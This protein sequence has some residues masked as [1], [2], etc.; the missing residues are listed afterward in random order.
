MG[1]HGADTDCL[2][3]DDNHGPHEADSSEQLDNRCH[4]GFNGC[5][6]VDNATTVQAL[7]VKNQASSAGVG[8]G[9]VRKFGEETLAS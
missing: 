5:K 8:E 1:L 4:L 9:K 6:W 3:N 2:H 7:G